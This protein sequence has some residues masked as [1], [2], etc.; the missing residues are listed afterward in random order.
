[1]LAGQQ[2]V[3]GLDVAVDDAFPVRRR[4]RS[5]GLV[6][7]PEGFVDGEVSPASSGWRTLIATGR[8]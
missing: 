4:Q 2:H 7:D 8:S 1:V 3:L 6:G 5:R